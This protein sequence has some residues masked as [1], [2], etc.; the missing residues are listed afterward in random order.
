MVY[1]F[2][3][4]LNK[5]KGKQYLPNAYFDRNLI[6]R[7]LRNISYSAQI[8]DIILL[9]PWLFEIKYLRFLYMSW[10]TYIFT[11]EFVYKVIIIFSNIFI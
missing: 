1:H 8:E 10:N 4:I 5:D 2:L 9:L 11:M 3:L 6:E 7:I